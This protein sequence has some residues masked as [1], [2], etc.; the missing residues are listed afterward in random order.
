MRK[1][2]LSIQNMRT[3]TM[4]ET[5]RKHNSNT[6]KKYEIITMSEYQ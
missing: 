5:L 4:D 2:L 6:D 1:K 3:M